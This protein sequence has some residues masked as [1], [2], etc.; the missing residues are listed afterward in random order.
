LCC[1][2]HEDLGSEDREDLCCETAVLV[3]SR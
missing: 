2:D 1:E 3:V